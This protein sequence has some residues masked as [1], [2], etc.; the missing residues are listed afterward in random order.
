M[1]CI[2]RG[3]RFYSS[4]LAGNVHHCTRHNANCVELDAHLDAIKSGI[5]APHYSCES[6]PLFASRS[7]ET[8]TAVPCS[9]SPT[10]F[11][12]NCTPAQLQRIGFFPLSGGDVV[13]LEPAQPE[14]AAAEPVG[15]RLADILKECGI[16]RSACSVC[17]QWQVWMNK[18]VAWCEE[19]RARILAR[20]NEQAKS[21][22]WFET[23]KVAGH[24]YLTTE[25][26]LDEAI[27]RASAKSVA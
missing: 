26:I 15:D 20:L 3:R 2:H 13:T 1:Q 19:N 22:S 23:I 27:K 7:R 9:T 16:K 17:H 6:C 4:K 8:F 5:T 21:A 12:W 25:S 14:A 11:T 18:G 24:G 10:G